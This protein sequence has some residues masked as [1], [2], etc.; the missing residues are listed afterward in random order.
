MA[1]DF[2]PFA[3]AVGANVE[4]QADYAADS[5]TGLGFSSGI[6]SSAKFNKAMRQATFV[7]AAIASW[8][9]QTTGASVSDDGVLANFV[10]KFAQAVAASIVSSMSMNA[11]TTGHI[12][13]PLGLII[14][15]GT[16]TTT[17]GT[18]VKTVTLDQ[19]FQTA[20]LIGFASN[21]ASGPPTAFHGTNVPTKTQLTV[22]SANASGVAAPSGTAFN[23]IAIGL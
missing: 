14:N 12:K 8:M 20:G 15:W 7:A 5:S 18:G 13:L 19:P 23:Y 11:A 22:F 4:A 17:D 21:A 16:G 10:T 2:L 1:S 3:T 6:A 9:T